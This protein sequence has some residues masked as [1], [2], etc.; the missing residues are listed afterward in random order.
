[1]A[2]ASGQDA[3]IAGRVRA[4]AQLV[5]QDLDPEARKRRQDFMSG[6][7]QKNKQ[8]HFTYQSKSTRLS[9]SSRQ[10]GSIIQQ[11]ILQH[12]K[13]FWRTRVHDVRQNNS[14]RNI[15]SDQTNR[16]KKR[17]KRRKTQN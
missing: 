16:S 4:A 14:R 7:L 8:L 2:T 1:M 13:L 12:I 17:I 5:L 15:Q 9:M 3:N 10:K 6:K 11:S